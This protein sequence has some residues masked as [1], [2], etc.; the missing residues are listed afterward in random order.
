ME[1]EQVFK[2]YLCGAN[3]PIKPGESRV[4]WWLGCSAAI[5]PD[6]NSFRSTTKRVST[7]TLACPKIELPGRA[8]GVA[9]SA[10]PAARKRGS[11]EVKNPLDNLSPNPNPLCVCLH[12]RRV[13]L[14]LFKNIVR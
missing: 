13:L 7:A 2:I 8:T 5:T 14:F 9:K 4:E 6:K 12:I 10:T 1:Q 11:S 3:R